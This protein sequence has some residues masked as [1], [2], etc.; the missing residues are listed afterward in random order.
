MYLRVIILGYFGPVLFLIL[1]VGLSLSEWKK[2]RE[3]HE[4]ATR[5]AEISRVQE[6]SYVGERAEGGLTIHLYEF[7]E[8]E[9][10]EAPGDKLN[11][12]SSRLVRVGP[13][14]RLPDHPTT[15]AREIALPLSTSE[16]DVHDIYTQLYYESLAKG[17]SKPL[18]ATG[19]FA[20]IF[21]VSCLLSRRIRK[22]L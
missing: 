1:G 6:F 16:N 17:R 20:I 11:L 3:R 18:V 22:H 7:G 5:F 9:L 15:P 19:G 21:V 12:P 13:D 4:C 14:P 10:F 8:G 2:F